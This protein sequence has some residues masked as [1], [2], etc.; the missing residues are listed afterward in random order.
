MVLNLPLCPH[1]KH[2]LEIQR[3]THRFTAYF[4]QTSAL[5]QY[6][7]FIS[8][9]L[10][11]PI[12]RHGVLQTFSRRCCRPLIWL[13]SSSNRWHIGFQDDGD[14]LLWLCVGSKL[15]CK[16]KR[17]LPLSLTSW[18][19]RRPRSPVAVGCRVQRRFFPLFDSFFVYFR[20]YDI[21]FL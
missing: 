18:L 16:I 10:G 13:S 3:F 1:S 20:V 5:F 7:S 6:S 8:G 15:R 19:T 4:Q 11:I 21:L 12:L 9:Q 14:V 2:T 17:G